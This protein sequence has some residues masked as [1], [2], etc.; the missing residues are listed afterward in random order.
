VHDD[1]PIFFETERLLALALTPETAPLL[2]RVF[3]AAGDYFLSITGRAEPDA[4]AA[5][6]ELASAA[7][8]PGREVALLM[9]R[10]SGEPV[11]ALGW[12]AGNPSP[13]LALLGML[14]LAP[15]HR[16][17][18][19]AR[20]ALQALEA[21]LASEGHRALRTAVGAGDE[22]AHALLRRLGFASLDERTHVSLDRGRIMIAFFEKTIAQ[23]GA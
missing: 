1:A 21:G 11:G 8:T 17:G 4:D 13:E 3:E 18:G 19:L 6:R 15:E 23:P 16:G 22:K 7:R 14:L 5:Q 9:L 10:D 20:E 2:Q 12:W